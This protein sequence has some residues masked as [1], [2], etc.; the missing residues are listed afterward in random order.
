MLDSSGRSIGDSTEEGEEGEE[1]EE[2]EDGDAVV[3]DDSLLSA[4][5]FWNNGSHP[6]LLHLFQSHLLRTNSA[7]YRVVSAYRMK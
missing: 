5:L 7:P 3:W 4:C 6:R 1:V 2:G